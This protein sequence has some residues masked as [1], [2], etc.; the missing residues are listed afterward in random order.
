MSP[1]WRP[2]ANHFCRWAEL[3]WVKLSGLTR[4]VLWPC[5]VLLP[6]RPAAL[7]A[8]SMSPYSMVRRRAA[9]RLAQTPASF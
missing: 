9:V 5:R 7:R 3:P 2:V 6:M 8:S 4:P 1:L